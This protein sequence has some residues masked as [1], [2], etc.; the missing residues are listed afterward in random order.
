MTSARKTDIR[1][2]AKT[3]HQRL[4]NVVARLKPSDF[5]L[6]VYGAHHENGWHVR[7]ILAHLEAAAAGMLQSARAIVAGEDPLP[8]N[9]DLHRWNQIKVRKAAGISE[10]VLLVRIERSHQ[11]WMQFLEEIP[12]GDLHRRG[13]HALGD[14]L[15]VEGFMLR[16]AEHEAHH[17]DEINAVLRND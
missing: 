6:P 8:S 17:A 11:N 12:D 16:Y 5:D 1:H 14:V 3:N 7:N 15:T 2:H 9:F 10:K 13:R 4:L